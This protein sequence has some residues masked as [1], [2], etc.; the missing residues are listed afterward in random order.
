MAKAVAWSKPFCAKKSGSR[1]WVR[2]AKL[3]ASNCCARR[4]AKSSNRSWL[5]KGHPYRKGFS[6]Q[7]VNHIIITHPLI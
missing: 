4:P 6:A 5:L 7:A 3:S 2:K 1:I